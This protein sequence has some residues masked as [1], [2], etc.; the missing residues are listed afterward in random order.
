[1]TEVPGTLT[2]AGGLSLLQPTSGSAASTPDELLERRRA[3]PYNARAARRTI[4]RATKTFR[5]LIAK[6]N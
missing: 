6:V 4:E 2:D 1:M 5:K 3:T